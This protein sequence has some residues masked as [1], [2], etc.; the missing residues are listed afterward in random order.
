[1]KVRSVELM[2][3][4]FFDTKERL[5]PVAETATWLT[6]FRPKNLECRI[7]IELLLKEF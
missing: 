7:F 4:G 2:D 1:M 5:Q 6:E 3:Q